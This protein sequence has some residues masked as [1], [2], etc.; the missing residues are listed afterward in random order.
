MT[1]Q[2]TI[3]EKVEELTKAVRDTNSAVLV[4]GLIDEPDGEHK[5][6][7]ASMYGNRAKLVEAVAR[8]YNQS[9]QIRSVLKSGEV[10]AAIYK[11]THE[12]DSDTVIV[13][14]ENN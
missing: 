6:V 7:V 9:A 2:E 8:L 12:T 10:I 13:R 5:S 3:S 1:N 11:M 4:V 14:E